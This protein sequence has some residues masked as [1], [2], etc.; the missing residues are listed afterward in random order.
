MVTCFQIPAYCHRLVF[1]HQ[2]AWTSMTKLVYIVSIG[3][4]LILSYTY[5]F[6]YLT[7]PR[8]SLR[9]HL[10][11]D[12]ENRYG[13]HTYIDV[14]TDSLSFE[15]RDRCNVNSKQPC[16]STNKSLL[17]TFWSE[18]SKKDWMAQNIL[19]AF[20]T[21]SF[22][23]LI[24][25]YDNSTWHSHPGYDKFIWIHVQGQIRFWY[26]KRFLPPST[27]KSYKYIWIV[28]DD[29]RLTFAPLHYQCVIE[30][31]RIPLSAPGRLTGAM[32][33]SITRVDDDFKD[34]I[35]RWTDFVETGPTFVAT[36][37]AWLCIYRFLSASTGS[38][39]ELDSIWCHILAVRCL[40][41]SSPRKVCA[42]LDAFGLDHQSDQINSVSYGAP[43]S[44]FYQKRF[45]NWRAAHRTY[46]P[47]A[48]NRSLVDSCSSW[49][50]QSGIT[51]KVDPILLSMFLLAHCP[52]QFVCFSAQ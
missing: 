33:H 17:M 43:E 36:S 20:P 41:N 28:D 46:G 13:N 25:V 9:R 5:F 14:F 11:A 23:H 47:L 35:G 38:G 27:I 49:G 48:R 34:R 6:S 29:S 3:L 45:Y 37:A 2:L 52:A 44:I 24:F 1:C 31:L 10:C 40:P 15:R 50:G 26:V 51:S 12:D 21:H 16:R 18:K 32:S 42:I 39:W 4:F 30:R 19:S 22:D 8:H 7:F